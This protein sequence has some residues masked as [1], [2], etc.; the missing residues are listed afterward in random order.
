ML[1]V[2][3]GTGL[4]GALVTGGTVLDGAAGLAAEIGHVP[5]FCGGE[6]CACGQRGC[7]QANAS[8]ASVSRRYARLSGLSSVLAEV[9]LARASHGMSTHV[10]FWTTPWWR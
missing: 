8:G 7:A 1:F 4:A 6:L 9:V 10:R 3:I 5:A 2:S